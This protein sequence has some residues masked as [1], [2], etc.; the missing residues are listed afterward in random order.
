MVDC[1]VFFRLYSNHVYKDEE[2]KSKMCLWNYQSCAVGTFHSLYFS[3]HGR[4]ARSFHSVKQQYHGGQNLPAVSVSHCWFLCIAPSHNAS[5]N[6]VVSFCCQAFGKGTYLHLFLVQMNGTGF[7]L[8]TG[9]AWVRKRYLR[10]DARPIKEL[11]STFQSLAMKAMCVEV[12]HHSWWC[13][14]KLKWRLSGKLLEP[15]RWNETWSHESVCTCAI[16]INSSGWGAGGHKSKCRT[17]CQGSYNIDSFL[18]V[19]TWWVLFKIIRIF[20][21]VYIYTAV[22]F[23]YSLRL[24]DLIE[25]PKL[26]LELLNG[27]IFGYQR[28]V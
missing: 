27:S 2:Q 1:F 20:L 19:Q 24:L 16:C 21:C 14:C 15:K 12:T 7:R 3:V 6:F 28:N 10:L 9:T 17:L 8:G 25:I 4:C 5:S 26:P 11:P 18:A 13:S 23:K 22:Y